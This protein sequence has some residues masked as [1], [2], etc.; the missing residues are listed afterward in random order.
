MLG[1]SLVRRVAVPALRST[2]RFLPLSSRLPSITLGKFRSNLT[3]V[4]LT[5]APAAPATPAAV[6]RKFSAMSAAA[7]DA[8]AAAAGAETKKDETPKIETFRAELLKACKG[9]ASDAAAKLLDHKAT[10]LPQFMAFVKANE[11]EKFPNDLRLNLSPAAL[12]GLSEELI[13]HNKAMLDAIA[14]IPDGKHTLLNTLLPMAREDFETE[15]LSSSLDFVA[16]VSPDREVRRWTTSLPRHEANYR[17]ARG[18][19]VVIYRFHFAG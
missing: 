19:A 1:W 2:C 8:A 14:A 16:H 6:Y 17:R 15:A 3:N 18:I 13:Q 11:S 12:L 7:T 9:V 4:I 5:P 10:P